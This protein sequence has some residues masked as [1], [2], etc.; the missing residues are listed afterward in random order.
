MPENVSAN[1]GA[2][3]GGR[4]YSMDIGSV[5]DNKG[6]ASPN[7]AAAKT[8]TLTTRTSDTVGEITGEASHGISTAD[9]ISIFWDGG[10]RRNVTVG[11]VVGLAI[12]F[13]V[14]DGDVL[15]DDETA[16]TFMEESIEDH[17]F[18]GNDLKALG[19]HSP[20]YP[21]VVVFRQTDGTELLP[22]VL[23]AGESYVWTDQMNITNPLAGDTV[24]QITIA[25]GGSAGASDVYVD[26]VKA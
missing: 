11:T 15:P 6:G 25:H 8:G 18:V 13:T 14:G 1:V 10:H 3:I 16:V 7:L 23:D 26:Y 21:A 5:G 9:K 12:P 20:F 17:D 4:Q 24:G 2:T 22:I 19:V